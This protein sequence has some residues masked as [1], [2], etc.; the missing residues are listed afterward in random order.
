[1]FEV[2][3]SGFTLGGLEGLEMVWFLVNVGYVSTKEGCN[4]NPIRRTIGICSNETDSSQFPRIFTSKPSFGLHLTS[5]NDQ[6]RHDYPT[7]DVRQHLNA[8]VDF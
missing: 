6:S 1:M 4:T 5:K 3:R 8:N 7:F 2:S